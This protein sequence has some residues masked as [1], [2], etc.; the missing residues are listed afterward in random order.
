MS[1]VAGVEGV[2]EG[3]ER[4]RA[5]RSGLLPTTGR[6]WDARSS[7]RVVKGEGRGSVPAELGSCRSRLAL[8]A[9]ARV[10]Q[11]REGGSGIERDEEGEG[12][13]GRTLSLGTVKAL[14]EA[15]V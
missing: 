6:E 11:R 10:F 4:M 3:V 14:R 2:R 15:S 7:C 5:I 12:G 9:A 13:G 8:F 1:T